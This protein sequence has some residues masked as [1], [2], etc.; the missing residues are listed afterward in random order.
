MRVVVDHGTKTV[1]R[2]GVAERSGDVMGIDCWKQV[3]QWPS[4]RN[5]N[6]PI[7]DD[8]DRK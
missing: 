4:E 1:R 5:L 6:P 3:Q 2:A 7:S 8:G